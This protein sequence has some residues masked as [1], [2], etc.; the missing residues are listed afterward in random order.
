MV[1]TVALPLKRLRVVPLGNKVLSVG[2]TAAV[3][4]PWFI[5]SC[6]GPPSEPGVC[7]NDT[8]IDTTI[9]STQRNAIV[10]SSLG[11]FSR[12]RRR[13]LNLEFF[14]YSLCNTL[15]ELFL[16][17]KLIF[18]HINRSLASLDLGL[19]RSRPFIKL[20]RSRNKCGV[21]LSC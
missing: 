15:D 10:M 7:A 19:R 12:A 3:D 16:L 18:P 6:G 1:Q 17:I 4:T 20:L 9:H 14:A 8:A 5:T 2:V 13:F 21:F 11:I